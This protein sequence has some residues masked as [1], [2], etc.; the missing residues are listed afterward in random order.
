MPSRAGATLG[1]RMSPCRL[2]RLSVT[3]FSLGRLSLYCGSLYCGIVHL[4]AGV[5]D[6]TARRPGDRLQRPHV[7]HNISV[8]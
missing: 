4:A 1:A 3:R 8:A 2:T 7:F 5:T 6:V